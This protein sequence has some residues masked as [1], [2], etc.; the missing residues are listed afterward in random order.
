MSTRRA[1][2]LIL[3]ADFSGSGKYSAV[4][5]LRQ[6][7]L[8]LSVAIGDLRLQQDNPAL[9]NALIRAVAS[10]VAGRCRIENRLAERALMRCMPM[11]LT[12]EWKITIPAI[13]SLNA[14]FLTTR[15][16]KAGQTDLFDIVLQLA[17]RPAFEAL[18]GEDAEAG[19]GGRLF[20]VRF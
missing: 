11:R 6:P 10:R 17:G 18:P 16:E 3:A 8:S 9:R 4:G 20:A 2:E 1:S 19:S 15:F 13:G 7:S 14:L 5:I 12:V